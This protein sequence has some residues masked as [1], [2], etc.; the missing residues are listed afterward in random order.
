MRNLTRGRARRA[1]DVRRG[2]CSD[3]ASDP[4]SRAAAIDPSDP[5]SKR[6]AHADDAPCDTNA[7]RRLAHARILTINLQGLLG[8]V[9]GGIVAGHSELEIV[10][11]ADAE[12]LLEA[13]ATREPD[14]VVLGGIDE[15]PNRIIDR[16]R[17]FRPRLRIV[18]IDRDGHGAT[19]YEP[20]GS[21]RCVAEVS[22]S[23]L[24]Q[25]LRGPVQ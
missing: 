6:R 16:L 11:E 5:F 20:D 18:T 13:V 3:S 9:M 10:G 2:R 17:T 15:E 12:S 1:A 14:V 7:E 23:M 19:A 21:A 24:V 4:G 22:P 25:M 8:G